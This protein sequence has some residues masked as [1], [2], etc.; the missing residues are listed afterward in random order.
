VLADVERGRHVGVLKRARDLRFELEPR[1][2]LRVARVLAAQHLHRHALLEQRVE[3]LE[4]RPHPPFADEPT[5][6]VPLAQHSADGDG[7]LHAVGHDV[8][9]QLYAPH[10][11]HLP[12]SPT[13]ICD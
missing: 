8:R 11:S 12:E 7:G 9:R 6:F 13:V 4:H 10:R 5:D 3:R 1:R 2:D